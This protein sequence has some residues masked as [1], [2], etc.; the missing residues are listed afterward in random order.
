MVEDAIQVAEKAGITKEAVMQQMEKLDINQILDTAGTAVSDETARR[1]LVSSA[2]DAA[3]DFLLRIL[4]SLPVPP[5][6]GVRDGLVYHL[7]NLSMEGFK[8]RKEDIIVEIAGIRAKK[9]GESD[10]DPF[11]TFSDPIP[12]IPGSD[13]DEHTTGKAVKATEL[14]IID[15]SNISAMLD[16]AIFSFEQT[17]LPYLKGKGK[18]N[19]KLTRGSIRLQFELRRRKK[20]DPETEEETDEWEP[21]L[22]LHDRKCKIGEIDLTLQGEGRVT[23]IINK[24]VSFFKNPLRDYVVRTI[25]NVLTNQSGVILDKL[26]SSLS[27]YWGLILRTAS[28]SMDDLVEADKTD[29][30]SV[31]AQSRANE[32]ELVWRERVALGMNLLLNDESGQLKVVDFPRGSQARKVA[33]G[34]G[35][36][37]DIFKGA[38]IIAVNGMYH[39]D[40]DDLLDALTD[41]ARPKSINFQLAN[42]EDASRIEE[43]VGESNAASN[44]TPTKTEI[45]KVPMEV[46]TVSIAKEG[47]LGIQFSSSPDN[48]GL[49]VTGFNT[50][51][52]N[53]AL[54]GEKTGQIHIGNI[55]A[56]INGTRVVADNGEGKERALAE[57]EKVGQ[58]RPIELGMIPGYIYRE[59]LEK[60]NTGIV[61][62]GGPEELSF[63]EEEDASTGTRIFF[64]GFKDVIG[65]AESGGVLIGDYLIFVNGFPVGAGCQLYNDPT[66]RGLEEVIDMLKKK[67]TYPAALTFARPKKA[68]SRWTSSAALSLESAETFCVT[69]D[70]Y[71]QIGCIFSE[72]NDGKSIIVGDIKGIPGALQQRMKTK[73][74]PQFSDGLLL[75][76]MEGQVVP[77]YASIAMVE[78]V[79]KKSWAD[80][81][82]IELTI[83]NMKRKEWARSLE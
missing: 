65:M 61:H 53:E 20:I 69:A 82:Q 36:D 43:W 9:Q 39:D 30:T 50:G 73:Y 5:F 80:K 24:L 58:T 27:N 18:A 59:V 3:L 45:K 75:E 40:Q 51:E 46:T 68:G 2:T 83:C 76:A 29:I 62:V 77:S 10:E 4:P 63:R 81:G 19:I 41:P 16:D 70:Y 26:N 49:V 54:L 35:F 17:Y 48:F 38:T 28:L 72:G 11:D 12:S 47:D 22:C 57:F 33:T 42:V 44:A 60:S 37:P 25:V 79:L 67:K 8:V 1:D 55:L 14:L 32:V 74:E 34:R 21:V 6:D 56:Y 13:S 71:H 52:Y 66:D 78:K 15:V 7:S 23:W 31:T 64:D